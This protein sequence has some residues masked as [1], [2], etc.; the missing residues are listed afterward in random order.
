MNRED[1]RYVLLKPE[2]LETIRLVDYEEMDQ[3]TAAGMMGVSKKTFWLD[4]QS[5]RKKVARAL[6]HG[7]AIR[8]QGGTYRVRDEN[9]GDE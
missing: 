6:V 2:E 5:A 7:Y 1:M 8:I 3:E 4:L 9:I